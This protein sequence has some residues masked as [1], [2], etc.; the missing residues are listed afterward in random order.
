MPQK[1]VGL[2]PSGRYSSWEDL[3]TGMR[4]YREAGGTNAVLAKVTIDLADRPQSADLA[5]A[6]NVGGSSGLPL[7]HSNG[8]ETGWLDNRGGWPMLLSGFDLSRGAT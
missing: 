1:I 5:A 4:I 7:R 3:E 6:T 2:D 8:C